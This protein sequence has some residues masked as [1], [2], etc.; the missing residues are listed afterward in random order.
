MLLVSVAAADEPARHA[1]AG[2]YNVSHPRVP[3]PAPSDPSNAIANPG[4][5]SGSIDRGWYQCGDV[6]AYTTTEH[7]YAGSYDA[8]A[9]TPT[10][11]AEPL[12]NS[13]ICQ[14]VT[15]PRGA[16]LTARLYQLSNEADTSFAFQEADL[17]DDRGNVVVNLYKTVNSRPEWVLGRWNLDAYAGRALWLYFG[18]HGDGYAKR[19]TEQFLDDVIL[20]GESGPPPSPSPATSPRLSP[21]PSRR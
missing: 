4:F 21:E 11:A 7:P 8:Y 20:T 3:R 19:S 1:V 2:H 18:V 17:L 9:G 15:I 16:L 13:G 6:P 12:G 10:G 5:E 14:H